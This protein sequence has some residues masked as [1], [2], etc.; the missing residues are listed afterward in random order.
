M[1][2][3]PSRIT[4]QKFFSA[5]FTPRKQ[6]GQNFLIDPNIKYKI[7]TACELNPGDVVL[8]IGAGWGA[9]TKEIAS[10]V[11]QV[12]AIET[13]KKL[14]Q[15]LGKTLQDS[16]VK[17]IHAD[18]LKFSLTELPRGVKVIGNLPYYITSPI[19]EKILNHRQYFDSVY[20]TVQ[21]EVGVRMV[22]AVNTKAYSAFS[23]FIQY[24]TQPKMLFK[25]RNT[26][27]KPVPKVDSCFMSLKIKQNLPLSDAKEKKLFEI[28]RHAF[29]QRRKT[30]MNTLSPLS[31]KERLGYILRHLNIDPQKRAENLS[32]ADYLELAKTIDEKN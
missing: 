2:N 20:I 13:D 24:Y 27:F 6:L 7:V 31:G 4:P 18:F 16:S 3:L 8:E 30:I 19:L 12:I 25:I 15:A 21:K 17:L 1:Q 14:Y 28:I 26:S 29:G 5:K 9:L 22:A 10:K 32:L 23:C 11:K